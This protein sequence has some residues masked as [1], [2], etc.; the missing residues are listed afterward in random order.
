MNEFSF[1]TFERL[2]ALSR[3]CP[4]AISAYLQCIS[5]AD[6]HGNVLF[7]RNEINDV[8]CIS[9]SRFRNQLRKLS[10]EGV[11]EFHQMDDKIRVI[12]SSDWCENVEI[13]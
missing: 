2:D 1:T 3:H 7:N 13:E 4:D 10:L 8:L 6:E 9:W 12:L 11:L 5:R